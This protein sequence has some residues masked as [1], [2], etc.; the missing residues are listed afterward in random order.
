[1]GAESAGRVEAAEV[2]SALAVEIGDGT[3]VLDL[4]EDAPEEAIIRCMRTKARAKAWTLKRQYARA[5]GDDGLDELADEGPD[6]LERLARQ[7][8]RAE[9]R[10][11]VEHDAE[12]LAHLERIHLGYDRA[13]I[14]GDLD[15]TAHRVDVVRNRIVRAV[16]GL[17]ARTKDEKK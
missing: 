7:R 4:P 10:R 16:T 11:A 15:C 12:A 5:A 14:A 9:M 2:V 17:W 6:V 3:L 1:L 8:L 13:E